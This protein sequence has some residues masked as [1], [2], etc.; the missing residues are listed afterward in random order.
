LTVEPTDREKSLILSSRVA[1]MGTVDTSGKP[2]IVPVCFAYLDGRIYVPVDKKPKSTA[3]RGLKRIKNISAH[4]D[5]SFLIDNYSEDWSELFYILIHGRAEI[6]SGGE[7]YAG[8]LEALSAK[9]PQYEKMRLAKA[10]LPVIRIAPE[11]IISWGN[12]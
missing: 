6:V 3:W 5:V 1:R 10:G 8:S 7:G 11:R 9:Y 2:H 4:P 12:L